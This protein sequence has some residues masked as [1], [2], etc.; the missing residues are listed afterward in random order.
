V[1]NNLGNLYY[2]GLGKEKDYGKAKKY[3][4]LAADQ[5]N[6]HAQNNLG[7]IYKDG[8]GVEQDY[9]AAKKYFEKAAD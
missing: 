7:F 6:V 9:G 3:Y 8:L 5:G 4:E 2:K 1:Q